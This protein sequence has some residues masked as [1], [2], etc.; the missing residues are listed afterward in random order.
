MRENSYDYYALMAPIF[1]FKFNY[2][3]TGNDYV[4]WPTA[5]RYYSDLEYTP[6]SMRR[7]DVEYRDARFKSRFKEAT[8]KSE[9]IT[10]ILL[11]HAAWHFSSLGNES[12]IKNKLTS[13]SHVEYNK[14]EYLDNMNID[15]MISENKNHINQN[16]GCWKKVKL[17]NY[18]P[19]QILDNIEKYKKYILEGDDCETVTHY[20]G[21]NILDK[22]V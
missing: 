10:A 11:H 2:M 14:S 1:N 7:V 3:N 4:V 5:Y 6:S 8:K 15:N 12:V 18:F 16:S 19:K 13:Y 22:E 20:Y 21:K 17:D 9:P